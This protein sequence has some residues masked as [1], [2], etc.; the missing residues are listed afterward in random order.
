VT[1]FSVSRTGESR[2]AG[3]NSEARATLRAESP[4]SRLSEFL[5]AEATCESEECES[6]EL[7][8]VFAECLVQMRAEAQLDL[9]EG[10]A[11][12]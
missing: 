4:R 2:K 1:S 5:D 6:G 11:T 8:R 3:S 12:P 10:A 9:G 7:L